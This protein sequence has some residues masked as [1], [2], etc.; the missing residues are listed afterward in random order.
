MRPIYDRQ[1]MSREK[2]AYIIDATAAPVCIIAPVSSWAVAV[3]S[4][5]S[6]TDGFYTFLSTIPYNLYALLT[7]MM[8]LFVCITGIDF[9]KMKK[10]E[11]AAEEAADEAADDLEAAGEI[12]EEAAE[13]AEEAADAE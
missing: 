13:A 9:G 6:K 4:E 3:A 7:I 11:E 1:K 2:L 5:V 12:V 10:A 8:V